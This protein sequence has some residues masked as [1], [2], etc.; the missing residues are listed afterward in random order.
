MHWV[1]CVCISNRVTCVTSTPSAHLWRQPSHWRACGC[2]HNC[3]SRQSH[4]PR[5]FFV[6]WWFIK[7]MWWAF[8]DKIWASVNPEASHYTQ[9][10]PQI[11]EIFNNYNLRHQVSS[12]NLESRHTRSKLGHVRWW[13]FDMIKIGDRAFVNF[14]TRTVHRLHTYRK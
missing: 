8:T 1:R 14:C 2:R 9:V 12:Q 13:S 7:L 10:S 6:E 5:V 11:H 4:A 3:Q